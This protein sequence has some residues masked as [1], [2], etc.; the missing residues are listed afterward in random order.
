MVF[1]TLPGALDIQTPG[2]SGAGAFASER[3]RRKGFDSDLYDLHGLARCGAQ[4]VR[5]GAAALLN[6]RTGT[7]NYLLDNSGCVQ[8]QG[9]QDGA[10]GA[11]HC[12]FAASWLL[13]FTPP[14]AD[15]AGPHAASV[16]D[17]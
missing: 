15:S 17:A 6:V 8:F 12:G 2:A 3:G 4:P 11:R 16:C 13:Q 7:A 1:T 14:G 5:S 9:I 10:S